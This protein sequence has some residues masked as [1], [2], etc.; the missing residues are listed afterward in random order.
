MRVVSESRRIFSLCFRL[1]VASVFLSVYPSPFTCCKK[2]LG[3]IA[4]QRACVAASISVV[5]ESRQFCSLCFLLFVASV[6]LSVCPSDPSP[7][8]CC[9]TSLG[10]IFYYIFILSYFLLLFFTVFSCSLLRGWFRGGLAFE[11][12][13]RLYHSTLGL[14]VTKKKKGFV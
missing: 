12:H 4:S 13:R 6:F 5:S 7:L 11:A 1:F 3:Y 8:T 2:T 9:K 14:R 10:Y